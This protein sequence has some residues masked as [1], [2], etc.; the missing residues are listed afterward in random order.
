MGEAEGNVARPARRVHLQLVSQAA[1]D[2]EDL[3][4]GRAHRPDR[5]E[6][7]VD[8]HVL[9]RDPVIGGAMNLGSPLV[10]RVE[11]VGQDTALAGILRLRDEALAHKPS[12]AKVADRAARRFVAALLILTCVSAAAWY[13]IDPARA[14]WIAIALLVVSCPCALS[15]ATPTALSAA[16]CTLH[17]MGVLV[18][19]GHA[20]E[21]LSAATHHMRVDY[22]AYEGRR[23]RGVAETVLSRGRV[24]VEN[25]EFK[26][27]AGGG[28]FLK[29]GTFAP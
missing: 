22:S 16:S 28:S 2:P 17:R 23:V 9:G 27:R 18:R 13:A 14:L 4:A 11:R 10:V 25:G 20:L 12:I 19:R 26:G 15:L 8:D 29:R 3:P 1:E 5:H 7:R 24:V 21:T 6:Q